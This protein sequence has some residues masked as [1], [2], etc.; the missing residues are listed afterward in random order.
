[1]AATEIDLLAIDLGLVVAPAGCGKTQLIADAIGRHDSSKPILILTHT[2][3]GVVALRARLDRAGVKS[4]AYRLSTIDGWAIKLIST[5]PLRSGYDTRIVTDQKQNYPA[6]RMAAG[7]LLEAGHID[8]VIIANFS[9][10]FVDEYQDCSFLQHRIVRSASLLI[11]TCVVGDPMQAIFGFSQDDPLA[12]WSNEVCNHYQLAGEL[13]VPWRWINAESR[14][15]GEWLLSVRRKLANQ[16]PIDLHDSPESVSI[17]SLDDT[18][19]DHQR[20]LSACATVSP[21]PRGSVLILGDSKKPTSQRRFASLTPGAVTVEAVHLDDLVTFASTLDL[22]RANALQKIVLFAQELMT[23]VG[24]TDLLKRVEIITRGASRKDVSEVEAAAIAFENHR[25]Y[26]RVSDLLVKI[27]KRTGTRIF[28]PAILSACLKALQQC[29]STA[30]L[31]F[32]DAAIRIREQ[33]RL[34]GR[35][36]PRKAVGSTLLLKGLEADVAVILN[37]R[38][39][40]ANDLYVAMTRGSRKLVICTHSP[41]LKPA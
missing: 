23:G 13:E 3:A 28:R 37:T 34:L 8:D 14:E 21:V 35:P 18:A 9:R 40:S 11:P 6:I 27:N 26:N 5:F 15:L 12:H 10:L 39:L 19:L 38:A 31:S 30:D 7:D 29:I 41:I 20:Q 16:E 2:N 36:L 4:S 22:N 32:R 1:M 24:A 25:T 33:N 17:V